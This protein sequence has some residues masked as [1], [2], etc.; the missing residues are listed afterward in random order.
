MGR[1]RG[2]TMMRKVG[3]EDDEDPYDFNPARH[4]KN[5]EADEL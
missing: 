1:N 2:Q 5:T 4:K 3:N